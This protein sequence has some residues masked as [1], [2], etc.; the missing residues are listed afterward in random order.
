MVLQM[1]RSAVAKS[2]ALSGVEYA[3]GVDALMQNPYDKNGARRPGSK[4]N[5]CRPDSFGN[6]RNASRSLPIE[7]EK[8]SPE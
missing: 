6:L 2:I 7:I 4:Y 3:H 1:L 8:D 5:V